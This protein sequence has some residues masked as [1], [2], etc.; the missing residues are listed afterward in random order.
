MKLP[1]RCPNCGSRRTV[2]VLGDS[3]WLLWHC[4]KCGHEWHEYRASHN[5]KP[6][7]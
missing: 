1:T 5:G 6:R 2:R 3:T 7:L 4:R